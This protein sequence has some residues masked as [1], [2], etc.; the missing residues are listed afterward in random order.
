MCLLTFEQL[1]RERCGGGV[2][3]DG[4]DLEQKRQSTICEE[5]EE[6]FVKVIDR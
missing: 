1:I 6:K 4:E 3:V 5:G 2:E